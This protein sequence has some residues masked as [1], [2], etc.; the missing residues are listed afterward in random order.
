M[1]EKI[2]E[3]YKVKSNFVEATVTIKRTRDFVPI[4]E[5]KMPEIKRGTLS[6]L[7]K[8]RA[9]LVTEIPVKSTELIDASSLEKVKR[10]YLERGL[11]L[12]KKELPIINEKVQLFLMGLLLNEMFG[13]GK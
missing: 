3:S 9:T 10:K 4:Y 6:I 5:L 2:L 12:L 7:E 1:E 8:I 11:E 13:L